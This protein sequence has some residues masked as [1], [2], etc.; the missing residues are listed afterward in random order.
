ML[1]NGVRVIEMGIWV[2]G[3]AAGGILADWGADVVKI[4]PPEGDPMRDA[5]GKIGGV[6][7]PS[8]PPFA[9]D[10][11][12]KRSVVVDARTAE[13]REL[14]HRLIADADIFLTNYRREALERMGVDFKTLSELNPGLVY[15]SVS[16]YGLEGP[17]RDRPGYDIGSFWARG[18]IAHLLT[19]PGSDPVP[20]RGGFGDHV[21]AVTATAGI[22][23]ALHHRE[24]TG[25]GQLVE[26]SLLRTATYTL[27][28]DYSMQSEL[29]FALPAMSRSRSFMPTTLCY[30]CGDDRWIWLIGVEMERH[31]PILL[32]ALGREDLA[33]DERF[34]NARARAQHTEELIGTL[35]AE[36]IKRSRDEWAKRFDE[37]DLW[38]APIQTPAEVLEDPQALAAGSF[39]DVP[40]ADGSG[41]TRKVSGPI[42]FSGSAGRTDAPIP[43]LGQHTD[44]ILRGAG[45]DDATIQELRDKGAI[46]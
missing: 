23:A 18:G 16:G 6:A 17:D 40:N 35:D 44:D 34:E 29:G 30:K 37:V 5:L 31:W 33:E 41:T 15:C 8:N 22:L 20:S 39:V 38:W 13:G 14:I 45:L 42:R 36:F 27:G 11:R 10:N 19:T 24:K 7:L 28:W 25:E 43:E 21:T 1:L 2:A 26:A 32:K 46:R 4:E 12:A 9:L 3:P